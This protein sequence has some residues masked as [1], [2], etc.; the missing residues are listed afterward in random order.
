MSGTSRHGFAASAEK[1][2][3]PRS[4]FPHDGI[5]S[6]TPSPK[7]LKFASVKMNNGIE[8]QNCA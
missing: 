6:I 5:G 3:K 2:S 4:R 1:S 8:I 7:M